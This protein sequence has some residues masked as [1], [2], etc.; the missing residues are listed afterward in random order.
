MFVRL[1]RRVYAGG[2]DSVQVGFFSKFDL[3]WATLIVF[4]I[5][6]AFAASTASSQRTSSENINT[7]DLLYSVMAWWGAILGPTLLS[8]WMRGLKPGSV[9]GVDRMPV[10][11]SLLLG[12]A[13]LIAALPL[14]FAVDYAA[15]LLLKANPQE[16]VQIFESSS[17][18]AQRIPIILLAVVVAPVAEELAFRGYLYG[19]VKRYCGAIPALFLSGTLFAL[20]HQN[21]TAF[22]PLF[23][24]ASVFALAYELSGSLLVPMTMHALFNAFTLI[25]VL[26]E[27]K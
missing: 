25:L 17:T 21:L 7:F 1:F 20:I 16:V 3:I 11:R 24:L 26:V 8:L 12:V 9:F 13:L 23:V 14:V 18:G 15:S 2:G 6:S 10:G 27:Q 22:F 5:L 4:I 19:V